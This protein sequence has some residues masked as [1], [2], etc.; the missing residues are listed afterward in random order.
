MGLDKETVFSMSGSEVE[1]EVM[2]GFSF[3]GLLGYS[4]TVTEKTARQ[5]ND[6][7]GRH[8]ELIRKPMVGRVAGRGE[9]GRQSSEAAGGGGACTSFQRFIACDWFGSCESRMRWR[10]GWCTTRGLE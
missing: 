6:K 5:V 1:G 2:T 4:F 7:K 8:H 3:R 9:E 10:S